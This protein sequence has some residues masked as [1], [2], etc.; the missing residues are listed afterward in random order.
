VNNDVEA[1]LRR[2]AQTA[3][4]FI[5]RNLGEIAL[6]WAQIQ[7]LTKTGTTPALCRGG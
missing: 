2:T 7:I 6:E 3:S 5:T 1:D 4:V